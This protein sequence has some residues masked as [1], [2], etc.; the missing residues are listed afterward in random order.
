M[1]DRLMDVG[2]GR[3]QRP[4]SSAARPWGFTVLITTKMKMLAYMGAMMITPS[5]ALA[6]SIVYGGSGTIGSGTYAPVSVSYSVTT[7][8]KLGVI[9]RSDIIDYNVTFS[10]RYAVRTL[11]PQNSTLYSM[12]AVL[13]PPDSAPYAIGPVA[14]TDSLVIGPGIG[15]NITTNYKGDGNAYLYFGPSSVDVTYREA[16]QVSAAQHGTINYNGPAFVATSGTVSAVP[17]PAMW[18]TM[19]LGFGLVGGALRRGQQKITTR[20][21]FA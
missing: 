5:P 17:E 13:S 4:A 7:D 10:D 20:V 9:S 3:R 1:L 15:F 16:I 18:L 12:Y 8:G 19:I 2:I 6:A 21:A 11:T 14:S